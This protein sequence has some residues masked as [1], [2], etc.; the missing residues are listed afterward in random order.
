MKHHPYSIDLSS[1]DLW[2]FYYIKGRLN[3]HNRYDSL[4]D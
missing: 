2:L 1:V 3:D 4:F